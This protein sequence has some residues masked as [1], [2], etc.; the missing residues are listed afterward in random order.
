MKFLWGD[1]S[2]RLAK[3]SSWVFDWHTG[4]FTVNYNIGG[5]CS[6]SHAIKLSTM[7]LSLWLSAYFDLDW[8][9]IFLSHYVLKLQQL[10]LR[11]Y[12]GPFSKFLSCKPS[13]HKTVVHAWTL[14][15]K[16]SPV[17]LLFTALVSHAR[18][19][20]LQW[21][22]LW[23]RRCLTL[24]LPIYS[25]HHIS[26]MWRLWMWAQLDLSRWAENLDLKTA[27]PV[28]SF[29]LKAEFRASESSWKKLIHHPKKQDKSLYIPPPAAPWESG[30]KLDTSVRDSRMLAAHPEWQVFTAGASAMCQHWWLALSPGSRA[31]GW[32]C[33]PEGILGA[34]EGMGA[35]Q[36]VLSILWW[37]GARLLHFK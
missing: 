2:W 35:N 15:G 21:Q 31:K 25:I 9:A 33:G 4:I 7:L 24:Q 13:P 14:L 11:N 3:I 12:L 16:S 6:K 10:Y 32:F 26:R 37:C 17:C 22:K 29:N 34:R 1:L 18:M 27:D 20:Y 19:G 36:A 23:Q 30:A 8:F 28:V 5:L